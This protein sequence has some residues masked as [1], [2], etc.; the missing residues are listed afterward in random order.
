MIKA[1]LFDFDGLLADSEPLQKAAWHAYLAQQGH[2][3]EDQLIGRMFGLRLL[4]SA[5]LVRD[6]LRLESPV[7]QI[8]AER[9]A[10]FLDSL[11][12][13]LRPMPGAARAV[14]TARELGLSTA[15]ATS[16]HRRY[17]DIAL[18]ELRLGPFDAIVTG[19][20]VDRGKPAPDIFL[21]AAELIDVAPPSCVVV[22]DAP[23]GVAAARAAGMTVVA[24][25]NELT[26]GLDLRQADQI[27]P[28]L[29][30]FCGWLALRSERE[31]A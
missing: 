16:G 10:I 5:Q 26:R 24:V 19:D 25:P 22:E 31:R 18:R 14:Q 1:V 4:E 3:L 6:E 2:A 29:D 17:I 21:R 13:V 7:E 27:C 20:T 23:H 15:L 12:G 9:D 11:A 8:M 30:A 28:S